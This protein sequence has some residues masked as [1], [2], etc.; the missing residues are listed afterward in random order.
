[1]LEKKRKIITRIQSFVPALLAFVAIAFMFAPIFTIKYKDETVDPSIKW[2]VTVNI[3][4]YLKNYQIFHFTFILA[5]LLIVI[6][7]V[8]ALIFDLNKYFGIVSVFCFVGGF[9]LF[10]MQGGF[11]VYNGVEFYNKISLEWGAVVSCISLAL[12]TIVEFALTYSQN[13]MGIRDIAEDGMLIALAF[14]LNFI[15]I[16][17]GSTGGSINLQMLPLFIIAIRHGPLQGVIASGII[18]GFVSCLAD[19]YPLSTYPFDYLIGFGGTAI[20]GFFSPLIVKNKTGYNLVGELFLFLGGVIATL[21]RWFGSSISSVVNFNYTFVTGLAYNIV[22]VIPSGLI[23]TF[24]IMGL[25]GPLL[26]LSN[27]LD[28]KKNITEESA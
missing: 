19:V 3:I 5:L 10:V 24:V 8:F 6:G 14:V 17:I 28:H 25:Y 9:C 13:K 22:Y 7:V 15:K 21:I 16:P 4:E 20:M 2:N 1:M 27:I 12:A 11:Y 26:K 23:A 18:Y